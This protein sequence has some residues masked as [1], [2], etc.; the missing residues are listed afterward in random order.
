MKGKPGW[1]RL[2][3]AL[4]GVPAALAAGLWARQFIWNRDAPL[5]A[6]FQK[7]TL[8]QLGAFPLAE[9]PLLPGAP[10]PGQAAATPKPTAFPDSIRALD[11]AE[12]AIP[13]YMMPFDEDGQ[14]GVLSFYLVRS[15]MVCCFGVRPRLNE[16]VLCEA[17]PGHPAAYFYNVPI[18]VYGKLKVGELREYGQVQ[19]LYRLKVES[20]EE[21]KQPDGSMQAAPNFKGLPQ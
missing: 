15:V 1:P 19:A 16:I 20:I 11:G 14:G 10:K 9:N 2:L 7:V 8:A 5:R 21:L 12:A 17:V 4:L 13:G 3:L 18:R 6:G